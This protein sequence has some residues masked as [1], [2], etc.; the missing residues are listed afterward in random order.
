MNRRA[1]LKKAA[2]SAA[3]FA[4]FNRLSRAETASEKPNVIYVFSDT[5]RWC[6]MPFTEAPE[7]HAPHMLALKQQGIT[8]DHCFSNLPIC[9]PYRSILQTG[10][11]P[12]QT[13][14]IENHLDL[15]FRVDGSKQ[16]IGSMFRTA[17]YRTEYYG[18][19]HLG[20]ADGKNWG[21][22]VFR[23][24]DG[25]GAGEKAEGGPNHDL[26]MTAKA[27]EAIASHAKSGR[28]Q[29]LFLTLSI[30]DPHGP[31]APSKENLERYASNPDLP[32]RGN[33]LLKNRSYY[34]N[35]YAEIT[36]VDEMLG[37]VM[38]AL[39]D[40]GM[41]KNTILIYTSDHGAMGGAQ[42]IA[43]GQKRMP[44]DES[45]RVPFLIRWP[46]RIPADKSLDVL[47][48]AI[49][50]FPTLCSLA[51]LPA[52]LQQND[53]AEAKAASQYLSE[54]PGLDF[55][56]N[57]LGVPG[58]PDP[59]SVFLMHPSNMTNNNGSVQ[60]YRCIVTKDYMYAVKTQ[61]RPIAATAKS[62]AK[63]KARKTFDPAQPA[64]EWCLYDRRKD[65]LQMNNLIDD[66]AHASVKAELL[67]KLKA[68]IAKAEAPY[69]DN[70]FAKMNEKYLGNWNYEHGIAKGDRAGA[71]AA[72]HDDFK[73]AL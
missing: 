58:G 59:E 66:P 5:H 25:G 61:Y 11:W 62:Q 68:W 29:P 43:G 30:V 4:F 53:S 57:L 19:W 67:E 31:F 50:I 35:Y 33:D 45:S 18:K 9:T 73:G 52:Q 46:D 56:R 1:F 3:A 2:V 48:S 15:H 39:D 14:N 21:Y 32:F 22:D 12:F 69:V 7:V 24:G 41:T 8:F 70:C 72:Y 20:P 51:N 27:V 71:V 26:Q 10:R 55:S 64:G 44:H 6:S 63:Q 47:F 17:G 38:K 65:P 37:S 42:N 54:C 36:G 23:S 13:G 28:A 16:T 60:T 34:D 40:N 49:D